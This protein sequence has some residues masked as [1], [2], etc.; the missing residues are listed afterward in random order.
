M[1]LFVCGVQ[2]SDPVHQF[3]EDI[4]VVGA[5]SGVADSRLASLACS[6]Q[7]RIEVESTFVWR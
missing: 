5:E 6:I 2:G 3:C 1:R 4:L 7:V